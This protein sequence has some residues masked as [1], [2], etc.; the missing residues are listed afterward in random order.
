SPGRVGGPRHGTGV[1]DAD[2]RALELLAREGPRHG[3]RARHSGAVP[4]AAVRSRRRDRGGR[5]GPA[6]RGGAAVSANALLR[7]SVLPRLGR[8]GRP[9][10]ALSVLAR[11]AAVRPVVHRH[12]V[13]GDLARTTV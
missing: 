2:A 1:A 11:R 9:R 8:T 13:R 3:E 4:S 6:V 12:T 10:A 5:A 7:V